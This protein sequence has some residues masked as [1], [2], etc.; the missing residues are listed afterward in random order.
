MNPAFRA[1]AQTVELAWIM[2]VMTVLFMV[3][4]LGWTWWAFRAKNR[5]RMAQDAQLPFMDGGEQ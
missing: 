3:C 4:F 2:G 1:A 5:D